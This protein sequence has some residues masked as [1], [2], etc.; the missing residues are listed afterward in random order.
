MPLTKWHLS[1]DLVHLSVV[2]LWYSFLQKFSVIDLTTHFCINLHIF[3]HSLNNLLILGL[4]LSH[5]YEGMQFSKLCNSSHLILDQ[6]HV[7]EQPSIHCHLMTMLSAIHF[8]ISSMDFAGWLFFF[9]FTALVPIFQFNDTVY[10]SSFILMLALIFIH[11]MIFICMQTFKN[12]LA[13]WVV[14]YSARSSWITF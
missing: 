6:M 3:K 1:V 2:W 9:W 11:I 12:E 10:I 13:L 7:L 8:S 14:K 4:C 5:K